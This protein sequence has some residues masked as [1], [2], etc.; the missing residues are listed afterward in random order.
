MNHIF[1]HFC[2]KSFESVFKVFQ[3]LELHSKFKNSAAFSSLFIYN[4]NA[5]KDLR[6]LIKQKRA[7]LQQ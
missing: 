2:R 5:L 6:F 3:C 4:T 7:I 1:Y